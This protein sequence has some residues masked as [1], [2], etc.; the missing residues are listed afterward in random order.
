MMFRFSDLYKAHEIE[1]YHFSPEEKCEFLE[2][3][4]CDYLSLKKNLS[5][6]KFDNR[7]L[8]LYKEILV[9]LIKKYGH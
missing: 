5:D 4:C 2:E 1:L 7:V 9:R 6:T 8:T 3:I